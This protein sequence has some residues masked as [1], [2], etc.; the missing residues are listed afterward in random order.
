MQLSG[1]PISAGPRNNLP[2]SVDS[3]ISRLRQAHALLAP[4]LQSRKGDPPRLSR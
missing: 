4:R 3:G 2:F 1:E